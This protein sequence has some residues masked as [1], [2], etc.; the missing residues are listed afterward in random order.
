MY[1]MRKLENVPNVE[2]DSEKKTI[3][4]A[5]DFEKIRK[6]ITLNT[7]A[8][9]KSLGFFVDHDNRLRSYS[10]GKYFSGSILGFSRTTT[11]T[12]NKI[13][14]TTYAPLA[15]DLQNTLKKGSVFLPELF[16]FIREL[17]DIFGDNFSPEAFEIT[18]HRG[19]QIYDY[20]AKTFKTNLSGFYIADTIKKLPTI[21]KNSLKLITK[22]GYLTDSDLA[23]FLFFEDSYDLYDD[24]KDYVQSKRIYLGTEE[25]ENR[26]EFYENLLDI[27]FLADVQNVNNRYS[28]NIVFSIRFDYSITK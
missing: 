5:E 20:T 10:G 12:A 1:E 16:N 22:N 21:T 28:E 24:I 26:R 25:M 3:L 19:Q 15:L 18:F 14:S 8:L 6:N 9:P 23:D 2:Y 11:I 17:Y 27:Q 7:L 13:S 4:F